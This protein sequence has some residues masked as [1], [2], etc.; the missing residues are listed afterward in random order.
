[1][2][3]VINVDNVILKLINL[4]NNTEQTFWSIFE[5]VKKLLKTV[6]NLECIKTKRLL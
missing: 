1:M 6:N 5:M 3:A 4:R 2:E